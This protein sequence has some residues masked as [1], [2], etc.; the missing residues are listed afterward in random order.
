[1]RSSSGLPLE[2]VFE[3]LHEA[4]QRLVPK[5]GLKMTI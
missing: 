1:M 5:E 4:V 2:Q 3:L